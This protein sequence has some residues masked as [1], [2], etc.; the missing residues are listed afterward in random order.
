MIMAFGKAFVLRTGEGRKPPGVESFVQA[1]KLLPDVSRLWTDAFTTAEI[2]CC[3]ALYLQC[4]DF[5]YGAYL[6]VSSRPILSI[7]TMMFD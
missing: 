4:V 3:A 7:S 1:M 2:F 5:R 6:T